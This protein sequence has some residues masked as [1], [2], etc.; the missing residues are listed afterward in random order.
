M[1]EDYDKVTEMEELYGEGSA[2]CQLAELE[3]QDEAG[4]LDHLDLEDTSYGSSELNH[5]EL[6]GD[7]V[8]D[9]VNE[10]EAAASDDETDDVD[11]EDYD[12]LDDY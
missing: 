4:V 10:E 1:T 6:E 12:P 3:A 11:L 5:V 9:G 2:Q 7:D 8:D